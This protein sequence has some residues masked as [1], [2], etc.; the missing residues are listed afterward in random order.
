MYRSAS[1]SLIHPSASHQS[2][3]VRQRRQSRLS[4]MCLFVLIS[5]ISYV[6]GLENRAEKL[7]A[8]LERVNIS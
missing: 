6:I 8:L 7:E 1:S 5:L 2:R 3:G 4:D